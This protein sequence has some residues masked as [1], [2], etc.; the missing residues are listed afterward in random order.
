MAYVA[1]N[2]LKLFCVSQVTFWRQFFDSR[3]ELEIIPRETDCITGFSAGSHLA[4]TS[5]MGENESYDIGA[6]M[7]NRRCW[8]GQSIVYR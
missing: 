7:G 5:T 2:P 1:P 4:P 3:I 8:G 6:R